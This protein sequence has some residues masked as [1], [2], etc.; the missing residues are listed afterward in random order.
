ML[1]MVFSIASLGCKGKD[2]SVAPVSGTITYEGK[3]IDNLGVCFSPEP[4]DGNYSVGPYSKGTTDSSGKF[5]LKT[6]YDDDGA[7]TSAKLR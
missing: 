3:P 5:S 1:L 2:Y 4:V 6:R 7:E